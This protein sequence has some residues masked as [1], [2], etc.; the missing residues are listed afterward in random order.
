MEALA[1]R[2]HRS[3]RDRRSLSWRD[4]LAARRVAGL[5]DVL[6]EDE[7][8]AIERRVATL[9]GQQRECLDFPDAGQSDEQ[10]ARA[11]RLTSGSHLEGFAPPIRIIVSVEVFQV[12]ALSEPREFETS[13][14]RPY[15]GGVRWRSTSGLHRDQDDKPNVTVC[16]LWGQ[17]SNRE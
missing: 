17:S 8:L 16:D 3:Q 11:R 13:L 10:R 5:V 9:H 1:G 4:I 15:R 12:L 2:G 7:S 14:D 6:D